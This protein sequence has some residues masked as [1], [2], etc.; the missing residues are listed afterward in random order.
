MDGKTRRESMQEGREKFK[1]LSFKKKLGYI[2]DYYKAVIGG[3]LVGILVLIICIQTM[4]SSGKEM[5]FS[6]ALINAEKT[7][8]G[9]TTEL[10]E[11]FEK[12]LG[13]DEEKQSLSLD[14]S[15]IIDLKNGDQVTVACQTKLM[16]SLQADRLDLILMPEDIYE[17]Y[18]AA[19][20]FAKLEDMLEPEF[21][22][23]V[24]ENW[25]PD[26]R[27]GETEDAVYALKITGSGKLKDIYGDRAVYLCVPAGAS[28]LEEIRTFVRYLLS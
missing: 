4:K 10:Q 26:R 13:L 16:A 7:E 25:Y 9:R 18:L 6:A 14:D 2:W 5:V 27:E 22:E 8:I 23:E 21:L 20:A 24:E 28:H 15:Y 12:H 11:D 1:N 19:G 3:V 17:N